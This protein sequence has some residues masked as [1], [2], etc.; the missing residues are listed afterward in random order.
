MI[1]SHKLCNYR[2]LV[3]FWF[4]LLSIQEDCTTLQEKLYQVQ[5]LY[6]HQNCE[7]ICTKQGKEPNFLF[8]LLLLLFFFFK[9][10]PTKKA[11]YT[12]K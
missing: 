8:F 2:L 1:K 12:Q 6:L 9:Y 7:T 4:G 5:L 10:T 3:L 11:L